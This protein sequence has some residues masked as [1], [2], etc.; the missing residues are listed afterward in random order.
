M[1]LA[2]SRERACEAAISQPMS[3]VKRIGEADIVVGILFYNEADTI[4]HVFETVKEG[5]ER[6]YPKKKGVIICA[7][8]SAGADA[9]AVVNNIPVAEE[10]NIK[11]IAF[12]MENEETSGKGWS[13]R[14]IAKLASQLKADVIIFEADL[15]S[16]DIRGLSPEWVR[17]LLEPIEKEGMDLVLP[18]FNH[19]YL[20]VPI[21]VHL[22]YPLL[23]SLYNLRVR[24]LPGGEIGISQKLL[25]V[26]LGEP[27][28]WS[29]DVDHYGVDSW[30]ITT[31]IVNKA[32]LCEANLGVKI[33]QS[34]PGKQPV[35][36]RQ[37]VKTLFNQI[38]AHR[39]WWRMRGQLLHS[40]P[41]FGQPKVHQPEEVRLDL[42]ALIEEYR[43]GFN[44]FYYPLY[45]KILPDKVC[46]KLEQLAKSKPSEFIFPA[47]LWG[48]IVYS[49]LLNF[50]FDQEF[51]QDD[52][53]G[54][55]IPLY[56]GRIASFVQE[57]NALRN[58]M[59]TLPQEKAVSLVALEAERL[60]EE[61]VK[62]FIYQKPHFLKKWEEKKEEG[63]PSLPKIISREFVP[64][65]ALVVPQEVTTPSGEIVEA[66][67]IYRSIL[68]SYRREFEQ[69]VH[70]RLGI[71]T[72]ASSIEI[73]QGIEEFMHQ[74]EDDFNRLLLPGDL[75]TV[76]GV[77]KVAEEIFHRYPHQDTFALKPEVTRWLLQVYPPANLLTKLGYTHL[78]ELFWQEYEPNDA[79]AL[80]SWSEERDYMERI[81]DWIRDSAH[82]EHFTQIR[83]QPLVVSYEQFPSLVEM[84][85]T[86]ALSR[87]TGRVVISN[88]RKGMGGK[89]PKLR[90]FTMIA[91][92]IVEAERFG[93]IWQE[94]AKEKKE[95]GSK[96]VNSIEGHW[97]RDPLSGHNIFESKNHRVL[98]ERLR[99]MIQEIA[100]NKDPAWLKL[101]QR[102][103]D[104][105]DFYHL[106]LA[107]PDGR[108]IPCSAWTWAS[109]SF[110]GGKGLP[111]PLSSHVERDWASR[112][113]LVKYFTALGGSEQEVDA[114]IMELMGE[115]RE[116]EDLTPLLLGGERE[117]ILVEQII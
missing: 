82:P 51:A 114:K 20:D 85:E 113:F 68:D 11:K 84:K 49:F 81:Q 60:I 6:F 103:K 12:L 65:V 27:S 47:K 2:T 91:K 104:V 39:D 111:S 40:L 46:R 102:L 90:Y 8:A 21:S 99:Q 58:S 17:L 33:H 16:R 67:P 75:H 96:I 95:F 76:A 36:L 13:W 23:A 69:L 55:L 59:K 64:G 30:L 28:L 29:S 112:E 70:Q 4:G 66:D 57:M 78:D 37:I 48:Q 34:S 19:H 74:V 73:G 87:L 15:L 89:F 53:V 107:L 116:S 54:G 100:T 92:N 105:A 35:V 88:L 79:L 106:A 1:V 3:E 83:L 62:E 5:L 108:F 50:A 44:Q 117:R 22:A 24:N 32:K 71:S 14:A 97:G 26:Y 25:N 61:Q 43:K 45:G 101:V 80:A 86:T 7:G 110:K 72:K 9:L 52:L 38:R 93:Q 98:V 63:K 115:G 10:S 18:R 42:H 94:F 41:S 31:A 109:Y 56:E 77:K